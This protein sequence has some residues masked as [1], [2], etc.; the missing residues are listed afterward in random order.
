[1]ANALKSTEP[2]YS[3][4]LRM[5]WPPEIFNQLISLKF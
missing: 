4:H 3:I 5:D 1:M 2:Y